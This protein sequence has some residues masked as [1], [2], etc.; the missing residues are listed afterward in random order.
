M[1]VIVLA[2]TAAVSSSACNHFDETQFDGVRRAGQALQTAT[3]LGVTEPK[4][5]ELVQACDVEASLAGQKAQLHS[6]R[7]V[8]AKYVDMCAAYRDVL[9]IWETKLSETQRLGHEPKL[10]FI[11]VSHPELRR[12]VSSYAIRVLPGLSADEFARQSRELFKKAMAG[13]DLVGPPISQQDQID[14]KAAID[15]VWTVAATKLDRANARP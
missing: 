8:A 13:D 7:A 10:G 6:E 15:L 12:V 4:Y 1:R 2:L 3:G 5:R 14:S 11:N 9:I